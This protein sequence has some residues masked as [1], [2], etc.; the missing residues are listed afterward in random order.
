MRRA[1]MHGWRPK[2]LASNCVLALSAILADQLYW[3][4]VLSDPITMR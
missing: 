2:E 3:Q 4:G 1:L